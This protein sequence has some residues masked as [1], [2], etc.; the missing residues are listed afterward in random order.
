MKIIDEIFDWACIL[1]G[2]IVLGILLYCFHELRV[3]GNKDLQ[4][5]QR[6][7][8]QIAKNKVRLE[9]SNH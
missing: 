8:Q 2:A 7:L 1:G 4:A 6:I 3:Q 5:S 9:A